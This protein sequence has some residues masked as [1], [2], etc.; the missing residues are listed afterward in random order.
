MHHFRYLTIAKRVTAI[1]ADAT[2]DD[3]GSVMSPFKGVGL[4]HGDESE[5]TRSHTL[6]PAAL[7]FATQPL[8]TH[9]QDAF[10]RNITSLMNNPG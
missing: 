4:G 10:S 3:L 8:K 6:L 9:W 5:Q 7:I 1:P 2:Q